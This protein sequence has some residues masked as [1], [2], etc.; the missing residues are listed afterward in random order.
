MFILAAT[1]GLVQLLPNPNPRANANANTNTNV[2]ITNSGVTAH[3]PISTHTH[4]H[5]SIFSTIYR[6]TLLLFVMSVTL[7]ITYVFTMASVYNYPGG[8]AM[9]YFD[10]SV[11]DAHVAIQ[12]MSA[13]GGSGVV[14]I[15]S[16]YSV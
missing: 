10:Y 7:L 13:D 2:T 12:S 16:I 1:V 11:L 6:A 4:T 15:Y 14:S 9:H 5:T 3:T 8:H